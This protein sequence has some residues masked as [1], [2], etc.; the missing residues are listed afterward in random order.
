MLGVD[1]VMI[2]CGWRLRDRLPLGP[3]DPDQPDVEQP[4]LYHLTF[5]VMDVAGNESCVESFLFEGEN[6]DCKANDNNRALL[7]VFQR[8]NPIKDA[9]LTFNHRS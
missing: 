3:P 9:L 4:G 8:I 6:T 5:F 1:L 7:Q 2:F